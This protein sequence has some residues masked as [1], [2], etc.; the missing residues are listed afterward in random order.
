MLKT[1]S[2]IPKLRLP[3]HIP[4]DDQNR[5]RD[6][7]EIEVISLPEGDLAMYRFRDSEFNDRKAKCETQALW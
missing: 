7:V 4:I 2:A 6:V 1:P 5:F 3:N